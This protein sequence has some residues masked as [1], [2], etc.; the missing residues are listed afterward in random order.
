MVNERDWPCTD[1]T[2]MFQSELV[3]R[4][5]E[6]TALSVEDRKYYMKVKTQVRKAFELVPEAY[7]LCFRTRKKNSNKPML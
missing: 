1:R 5:Q 6:Y 2:I 3:G 7:R 4:A